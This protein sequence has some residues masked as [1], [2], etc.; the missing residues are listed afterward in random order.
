MNSFPKKSFFLLIL[1]ILISCS[2]HGSNENTTILIKTSSGDIKLKLYDD[3]P[4]HR[5]NFI[6][7]INSGFYEG[8]SFHRIIKNFMIQAGDPSTKT[9]ASVHHSDSLNTY[10]IPSEI[11][12][13]HFHKKGAVAA[14]RS[15]I[16]INPQMRSAGTQFYIVEGTLL[17]DED[18]NLSELRINN[19][20][21]QNHFINFVKETADSVSKAGKTL[22]DAEIQ[23]IASLKMFQWLSTYKSYKI[24]DEQRKIYKSVGGTPSL[25]ATY[26]VF[27]EVT[28]G[29]DVVDKISK[30][31]TNS[32]DK[33]VDDIKILKMKILK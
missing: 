16:E 31:Q 1:F 23:D 30:V 20:I 26:T 33:P 14:A 10:T 6:K 27:G 29:L 7:L 18:L 8:I 22:T 13:N 21:K 5:D 9:T 17:N 28:E 19:N 12:I 24:S 32:N 25:D 15:G 11:N 3:T 4:I 2:F